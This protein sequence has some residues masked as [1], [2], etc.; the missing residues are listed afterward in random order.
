MIDLRF[1]IDFPGSQ[2]LLAKQLGLISQG[3]GGYYELEGREKKFRAGEF[4]AVLAEHPEL[5]ERLT[6]S[7]TDWTRE[8]RKT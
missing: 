1:G 7:S 6:E 2:L 3:G 5:V 8:D 4:E